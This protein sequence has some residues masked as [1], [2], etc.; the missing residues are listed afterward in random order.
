[1]EDRSLD[2]DAKELQQFKET[3]ESRAQGKALRPGL[4]FVLNGLKKKDTVQI[5]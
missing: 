1:M 2:W 3:Q 5:L 4:L